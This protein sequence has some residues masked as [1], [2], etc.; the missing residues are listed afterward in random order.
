MGKRD[1]IFNYRVRN[2]PEYNRALVRR[3]SLTLWV[4]EQAINAWRASNESGV[5]GGRPRTYTDT[6]IECALVVKAVFHLSLRSTQGFLESVDE[7][8]INAWRAS[9]DSGVRGGRPRTPNYS[10]VSRRQAGLEVGLG[11]APST[12]A[13]HVVIDTTGLKVYGAGE[14]YVRKYGMG[15]GRRRIWRKLHLG[16]DETTKEI[17]VVDLT[18]SNLH[19]GRHLPE[20]LE[21]TPGE[22]DQV[23]ADK[24]YDSR[25]CYEAIL[26]RQAK[27]TIPPRRRAG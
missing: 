3:G 1:Y 16:V 8:A 4:D 15:R 22:I 21:H 19:D 12:R 23:S 11:L 14:W 24:A 20:L 26:D 13:R 5:R 17:V 25:S 27:P 18:T 10:T 6:A 2:W 7:Q 9:N